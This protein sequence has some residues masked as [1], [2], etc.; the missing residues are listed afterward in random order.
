MVLINGKGGGIASTGI[1]SPSVPCNEVLSVINVKPGKCY[2]LRLIGG[3]ALSFNIF[4]IEDHDDLQ[5]IEADAYVSF[6]GIAFLLCPPFY[7]VISL[8]Q[9]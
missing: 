2:R 5:V 9:Y 7:F 3:T 4:A 6:P 1:T 8:Y